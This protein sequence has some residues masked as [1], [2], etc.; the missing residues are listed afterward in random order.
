MSD[1]GAGRRYAEAAFELAVRDDK[2]DAWQRD[3]ALAAAMARDAR[4]VRVVDNPAV[5]F[6][7]RRKVVEQLL[8]KHVSPQALN[9]ALLLAKRGRF[10]VLPSVSSEYEAKVRQTRGIVAATVTTPEPLSARELAAVQVRVEQLTGAKVELA[11]GVDPGLIGG[12]T[13]KIGDRLIDASVRGR[14]ERLR[15]RLI[16]GT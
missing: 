2:V 4:V 3:L 12:L 16:Q 7:E 8:G 6:S 13:I 15:G 14:L 10:G 9:L 11:T 1:F 5:P